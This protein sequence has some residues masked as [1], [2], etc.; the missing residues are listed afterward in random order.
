MMNGEHQLPT[1]PP[2]LVHIISIFLCGWTDKNHTLCVC[3]WRAQMRTL[4]DNV[5]SHPHALCMF[6]ILGFLLP[7][8]R[9]LV[10]VNKKNNKKH[11]RNKKLYNHS[12]LF[13]PI[14]FFFFF[15]LVD[16][17][18]AS[19]CA[20]ICCFIYHR[21]FCSSKLWP[22]LLHMH[23]LCICYTLDIRTSLPH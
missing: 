17:R 19:H 12:I 14:L 15:F 1:L 13:W 5:R 22:V 21:K 20:Y 18:A 23:A 6:P 4:N 11:S 8:S 7:S 2:S 3:V 10:E 16:V 9:T